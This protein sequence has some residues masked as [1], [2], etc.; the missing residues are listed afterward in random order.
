LEICF[1]DAWPV[2]SWCDLHVLMAVSGG[3]DSVAML[4]A[5]LALK[6]SSGGLG[7]LYVAHL[8]HGLR[9]QEADADA[10]WLTTVCRRWEIPLEVG[11]CDVTRHAEGQRDGWEAA[12]RTA[13]YEFLRQTAEKLGARFVAV[14]HTADD[15]VETVVQRI[16]RGT[17]IAGLAGMRGTRPLSPSVSLVRPLLSVRRAEVLDYLA[18]LGQNYRTDSTNEDLQFTRNRLRHELLPVMRRY[19]HT[20]FDAAI[21]RLAAHAAESQRFIESVAAN[22]VR[23]CV[24]LEF[25]REKR[26]CDIMRARGARIN[27]EALARQPDLIVREICKLAWTDAGWP[28]QAMGFKEWQQLARMVRAEGDVLTRIMPGG[29]R[30]YRND[31]H[32][33]LRSSEL[34]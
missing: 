30:V 23:S 5:A 22:L 25:E 27:C 32:L 1:K 12:A 26:E 14:A 4:R 19:F 2:S 34:A 8:N 16:I 17:G 3:A 29:V 15:Q 9:G 7:R 11:K 31:R 24:A 13:R 10:Q 28:L 6:R 33:V 20:D 21:L 18:W